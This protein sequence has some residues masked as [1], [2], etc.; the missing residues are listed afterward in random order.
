MIAL[1]LNRI[2][3]EFRNLV[4]TLHM[5]MHALVSVGGVEEEPIG[6]LSQYRGHSQS[7]LDMSIELS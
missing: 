2:K 4:V 5:N 3:P 6:T 1:D 7:S